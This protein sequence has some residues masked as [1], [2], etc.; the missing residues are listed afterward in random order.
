MLKPLCGM[1]DELSSNLES[2]ARLD[3]PTYEVL[4]GVRDV[5]DAAYPIARQAAAKWPDRM[6]VV[7]Q[8]GEPGLNPKVNQL[9]TLASRARYPLLVVSDSNVVAEPG[10]LREVAG[11]LEDSAVGLVTHPI[12][13]KGERT[14]GALMDNAHLC[15]GIAPG[16]VAALTLAD[17]PIVVG[18]SMALRRSDLRTLGGFAAVKDVLAEDFVLGRKVHDQLGKRVAMA[19]RPIATVCSARSLGGFFDR[20]VRWATIQR[21]SVG[22]A[23]Y[24]A[25][26]LLNPVPVALLAVLLAPNRVTYAAMLGCWLTKALFERAAG[27]ALRSSGFAARGALT[28]PLKDALLFSAWLIGFVRSKVTWRGNALAVLDGTR[29]VPIDAAP[30]RRWRSTPGTVALFAA[31]LFR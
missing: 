25:M 21:R 14:L 15:S 19:H 13:A 30:R 11:Y 24:T 31:R 10:Y 2:F 1:D 6:R 27:R 18:K 16:L 20:Y 17:F 8:R 26:V 29:L 5:D 28:L 3:Y 9:I 12:T 7:L 23:L 22:L 4:L